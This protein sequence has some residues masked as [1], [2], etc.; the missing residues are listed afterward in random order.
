MIVA[1]S[2]NR[3]QS[4]VDF[5]AAY[6]AVIAVGATHS[7]DGRCTP[8]EWGYDPAGNPQGSNYGSS[9]SIV[10]PGNTIFSTY[11][12]GNGNDTY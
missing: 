8:T 5:P 9:L 11:F 3:N 2:G 7:G 12:D 6:S 1:S 4:T 10:A